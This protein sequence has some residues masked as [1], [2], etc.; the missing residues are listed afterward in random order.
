MDSKKNK[1]DRKLQA[2]LSRKF[3]VRNSYF[4]DLFE[5]KETRVIYNL[6]AVFAISAFVKKG[7]TEYVTE[8]RV[9]FGIDFLALMFVDFDKTLLIWSSCLGASCACFFCFKIW[10]SFRN[11]S[12]ISTKFWDLSWT[13]LLLFYYWYSFKLTG[14][15][16]RFYNL[17]I[18]AR[19][20]CAMECVRLVMKSHSFVRNT[21]PG[22]IR[23]SHR[24]HLPSFSSYVRF[25]FLPTL[26]YHENYPLRKEINWNFFLKTLVELV[27]AIFLVSF[28]I[29]K[30]YIFI[31]EIG[32]RKFTVTEILQ[33]ALENHIE[34]GVFLLMFVH[35]TWFHCVQNLF[36]E[37]FRFGDRLFHTNWWDLSDM[38]MSLV[39]WNLLVVDWIY[40]YVYLDFKNYVYDNIFVTRLVSFLL[41]VAVHE[42]FG[43]QFSSNLP[44]R[45]L[46]VLLNLYFITLSIT[47]GILYAAEYTIS[48]NVPCDNRSRLE[49]LFLPRFIDYITWE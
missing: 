4:T 47:L 8:G 10:A 38:R 13:S 19:L 42:W 7:Y 18:V 5:K 36:G 46:F 37:L 3:V 34:Y 44:D 45:N 41:S 12:K 32:L 48:I 27:V 11:F 9:R 33:A 15:A 40:Y 6:F 43:Y 14:D 28:G 35:Y 2:V 21:L 26:I 1:P 23:S 25:L 17:P 39:N 22:V 30:I 20:F 31:H 49:Q 24:L 16:V 29:E